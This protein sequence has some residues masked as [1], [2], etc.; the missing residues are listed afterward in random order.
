V[1]AER[2]RALMPWGIFALVLVVLPHLPGFGS[3]YA[4]SLLSQMGI[5]V[6]FALSYNML[7]GHT[8]LLSFGHAV[9]FGLGAFVA[10]HA[11]RWAA[12]GLWLPIP[13]VPLVGGLGGLFFA[14]LLGWP[15]T[16]RAG[17]VF[18]MISLGIA[19]MVVA[20]S[21]MIVSF[22]GGEEGIN[23]D[24]TKAPSFLG[25]GFGPQI[26]VY[27]VIAAWCFASVAA[28]YAFT[29]T[30][31][32]RMCN[33]V[34][35]NPERAEFVGYNPQ[36]VRYVA[37]M[38]AGFFAG[39]AGGL[40]A[41]NYEIVTAISVGAATS[42]AVLLMAFIGGVGHFVGPVLG[43]VAITYLQVS[44]SDFTHAWLLY[45]GLMFVLMVLFAPGGLAGLWFMHA[46]ILRAGLGARLIGPYARAVGPALVLALGA[47][48]AIE[49]N[50]RVST[51]PD[52]GTAFE[53]A[54]IAFDASQPWVWLLAG[55]LAAAG[56]WGMRR[57]L[58]PAFERH[59][60]LMAEAKGG[61]AP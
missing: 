37:F 45:F 10:M 23:G 16:R 7:L 20:L 26:E 46:P 15:S 34:R 17:T 8:G 25:F 12:A 48:I 59:A 4:V 29:R 22:F 11:V 5:A 39:I 61:G 44:L 54:G 24:R 14:A 53:F 40:N 21:Y 43:A 52:L 31:V 38:A 13:L 51:R 1:T 58:G 6:I 57:G 49:V 9:Y 32:G 47:I 56:F 2:R 3:G 41:I 33:A 19:E 36:V 28:M 18:A 30:P 35:D 60:S 27:Y 55:S 42:G 50:Y